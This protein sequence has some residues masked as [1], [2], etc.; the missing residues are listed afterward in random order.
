MQI[1]ID[2]IKDAKV[3]ESYTAVLDS[4]TFK[5]S[6]FKIYEYAYDAYDY[7]DYKDYYTEKLVLEDRWTEIALQTL[8][9]PAANSI[10]NNKKYLAQYDSKAA[11][12]VWN[13]NLASTLTDLY[14]GVSTAILGSG[15][16]SYDFMDGYGEFTSNLYLEGPQTRIDVDITLSEE[17]AKKFER[18]GKQKINKK[19]F[20]YI[21]EENLL[22]YM[23][24]KINTKNFLEE[25]PSI[26]AKTY[27]P[28]M[29]SAYQEEMQLGMAFFSL[30]L[31]EEAVA[32]LIR[33]DVY[34]GLSGISEKEVTYFDYEYDEDYNYT[35]I[36]KTKMETL[37]EFMVMASTKDEN[38]TNKLTNYLVNKSLIEP[39]N[40]YYKILDSNNEIPLDLYFV[41]KNNIFFLSTSPADL[42]AIVSDNFKAKLSAKHKKMMKAGNFS[43]FF[44]G[45]K[46]G[47][48]FPFDET[49]LPNANATRFAIE[50]ASD[51]YLKSS[52]IK[53]RKMHT[54][55]IMQI[56][57]HQKNL[58]NYMMSLV[59]HL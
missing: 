3:R 40:G 32:E 52:K 13:S 37:P 51:F 57:D 12:N 56:P 27:S 8:M 53:N 39:E 16:Q 17:F 48:K 23:S 24:Y 41:I 10:L 29:G 9:M 47:Q 58:I 26:F 5:S 33:G 42:S 43:A 38:F 18:M 4:A 55:L 25:Y 49:D 15:Y 59:E 46:F 35:E 44:N 54:E 2:Q 20:R 30:L 50:N 36:E 31:D 6:D 34:F 45:S 7:G 21:N 1:A 28:L 14:S 19:F 22:G 11:I